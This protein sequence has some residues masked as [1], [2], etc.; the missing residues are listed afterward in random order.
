MITLSVF[1]LFSIAYLGEPM[2]RNYLV[3][4]GF[5]TMA[6]FFIFDQW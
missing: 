3:G 6:A 2:K 1:S 4:F 5:I